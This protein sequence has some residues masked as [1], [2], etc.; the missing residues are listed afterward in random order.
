MSSNVSSDKP[1]RTRAEIARENGSKSKGAVTPE[2]QFRAATASLKHGLTGKCV[3]LANECPRKYEA[4]R[5]EYFDEWQPQGRTE[6]DLLITA[7]NC[8]WRL[9]RVWGLESSLIDSAMFFKR[10][11]FEGSYSTPTSAMRAVDAVCALNATNKVNL[12]TLQRYETTYGRGYERALLTLRQL[13]KARG[14]HSNPEPRLRQR[15][16]PSA[17]IPSAILA[18]L[19]LPSLS[20]LLNWLRALFMLILSL[21]PWTKSSGG[22]TAS[23]E[24]FHYEGPAPETGTW[25]PHESQCAMP[26]EEFLAESSGTFTVPEHLHY[27]SHF[28]PPRHLLIPNAC[29]GCPAC[30]ERE[31]REERARQ[32][33]AKRQNRHPSQ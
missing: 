19:T 2:G 4:L 29:L 17:S 5:K 13:R 12:E 11:E 7:I 9:Q 25:Q 20:P 33:E 16:A 27:E 18:K 28:T 23:Q 24:D 3:V 22:S 15:L 14:E 6:T 8:N 10:N 1:R 31:E 26:R 21:M 32:E 30:N